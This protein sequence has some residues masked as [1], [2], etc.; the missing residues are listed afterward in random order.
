MTDLTGGMGV[1]FSFLAPLFE[2]ATYIEQQQHLCEAARHN[3][4]VL[5]ISHAI[6]T[7]GD[8]IEVL[9]CLPHQQLIFIDPARRDTHGGRT[10]AISDCTPNILPILPTLM[11]K[12]DLLMVKLSPM[13]DWHQTAKLLD[14]ACPGALRE[15]HLIATNNECKELLVV[16]DTRQANPSVALHCVNDD[17][18]FITDTQEE[19]QLLPCPT[20]ANAEE[21]TTASWLYEPN[22]AIMKAGCFATL[23]QRFPIC[24]LA[25]NSH[26][27]V[28]EH[29]LPDFPGRRLHILHMTTTNKKQLREALKGIERAN[30]TVRNF[31]MSADQLRR[32]LKIGDGGDVWLYA[33]TI[34]R[35]EHII[36]VCEKALSNG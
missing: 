30:I 25:D 3:F 15:I 27:F 4:Q 19:Q 7:E 8:G 16:L 21:A 5:G 1:D 20:L 11:E 36:F 29:H 34:L 14:A 35:H 9:A 17:T 28:S 32:K 31:P 22:A 2:K 24:A 33:S 6:V 13:L 18:R 26:L 12:T 10:F 23:T